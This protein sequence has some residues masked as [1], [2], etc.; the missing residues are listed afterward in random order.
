VYLDL[1]CGLMENFVQHG[2]KRLVLLNG[3]GGND[4]PARQVIF[5]IRQ[6]NRHKNDLLL[7]AATYWNLG[8]RPYELDPSLFQHQMGHAC[9]W[10]TSMIL[11]IAPH[12]VADFSKLQPVEPG[13]A[14]EPAARGW[15]TQ[16]R[17]VAGHIG[18]PHLATPQKGE[19][20][21][22]AFSDGVV[23]LLQRVIDW[24]GKPWA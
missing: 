11:R 24:D 1:L 17:T 20:L 13:G 4:V 6:R 23:N 3:H 14:F 12:L 2:F 15:V 18:H 10:E 21:L 8:G 7:L 9:E 5:E 16:D 22:G 19:L